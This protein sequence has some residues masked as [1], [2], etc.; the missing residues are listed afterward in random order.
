MGRYRMPIVEFDT[1]QDLHVL[2]PG[3]A[4]REQITP[5]LEPPSSSSSPLS[6][7]GAGTAASA[8]KVRKP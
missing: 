5:A 1:L 7:S 3:G 6:P 2:A 4:L 8:V